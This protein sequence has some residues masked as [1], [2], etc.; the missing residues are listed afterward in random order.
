MLQRY[1]ILTASGGAAGRTPGST[2]LCICC[3]ECWD[4][5]DTSLEDF[6]SHLS[7]YEAQTSL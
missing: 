1:A 3:G 6:I 4:W 5:Q 7:E 2:T